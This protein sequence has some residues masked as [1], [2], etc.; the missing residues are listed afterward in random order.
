MSRWQPR[1]AENDSSAETTADWLVAEPGGSHRP[2]RAAH[3]HG[4]PGSLP[5]GEDVPVPGARA[6]LLLLG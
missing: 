5:F 3:R 6:A 4:P 2:G 1:A